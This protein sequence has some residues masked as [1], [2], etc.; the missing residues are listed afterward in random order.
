MFGNEITHESKKKSDIRKYLELSDNEK[1]HIRISRML[2]KQYL[3]S[4]L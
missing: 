1:Q 3:G 2:L 4:N